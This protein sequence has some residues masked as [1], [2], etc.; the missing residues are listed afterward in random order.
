MYN[1]KPKNIIKVLLYQTN[2][3]IVGEIIT[4]CSNGITRAL[5]YK[6][7]EFDGRHR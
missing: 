1:N 3:T 5:R 4:V 7:G 6:I 2:A